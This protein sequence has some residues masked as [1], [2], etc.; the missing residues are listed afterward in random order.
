MQKIPSAHMSRV[1]DSDLKIPQTV[2]KRHKACFQVVA[3]WCFGLT[4]I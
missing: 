3:K 1:T 4:K 2:L